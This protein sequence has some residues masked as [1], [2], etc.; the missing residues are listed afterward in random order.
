MSLAL[1]HL[2]RLAYCVFPLF[3]TIIS[4]LHLFKICNQSLFFR[5]ENATA[6]ESL[7][8]EHALAGYEGLNDIYVKNDLSFEAEFEKTLFRDVPLL[9]GGCGLIFIYV[10]ITTGSFSL[11]GHR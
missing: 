9:V 8:L 4:F 7:F 6:W 1:V 2:L 10:F 3:T 5:G 11:V